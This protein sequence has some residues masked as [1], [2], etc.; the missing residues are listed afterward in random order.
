MPSRDS[1]F[2]DEARLAAI[3]RFLGGRSFEQAWADYEKDGYIVFTGII[4]DAEIARVREALAPHFAKQRS[5]RNDFEGLKSYREYSLLSKGEI[6]GALAEHPLVMAFTEYEFGKSAIL[7]AFL[8]IET[9]PGETVQPWH[10]DDDHC[11]MAR[12]RLPFQLSAFWAIDE[13]TQENGA[14]EIIAGSHLWGEELA[15][16]LMSSGAFEKTEIGDVHL[17][18]Q[19][20][21]DAKAITLPAGALMLAKG[22][23]YHR[24]GANKSDGDRLILTPQ[25]S[26]GWVRPLENMIL[27]TSPETAAK[28]SPRV[29]EMIGYSIHPPFMGYVDGMHPQ[30]ALDARLKTDL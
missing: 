16:D 21:D 30:R 18:P 7:S 29:R 4:G 27:S 9:H 23:L 2:P 3:D 15:D 14:T 1:Y 8:A 10:C 12:P 5:G 25:Y 11:R 19:A 20:R 28:L 22:T 24:G 13:T 17:D 26:P 6:F